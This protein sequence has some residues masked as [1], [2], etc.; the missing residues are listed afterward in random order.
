MDRITNM[1]NFTLPFFFLL[2]NLSCEKI[3]EQQTK[4]ETIVTENNEEKTKLIEVNRI[5]ERIK[6]CEDALRWRINSNDEKYKEEIEEFK[7]EL[8]ILRIAIEP[9][10]LEEK[11]KQ[12][13]REAEERIRQNAIKEAKR[14]QV[15]NFN[16]L[17][18]QMREKDLKEKPKKEKYYRDTKG[19]ILSESE[20]ESSLFEISVNIQNMP[21]G[22]DKWMA[23]GFYEAL[24][25]EYIRMQ[26]EGPIYEK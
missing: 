25:M 3:S 1:L 26:I 5:K 20:I 11:K 15:A 6:F 21:D 16:L 17:E 18:Q 14:Q 8:R 23:Q 19:K 7:S 4:Q 10:E 24:N 13:Q 12:D 2:F 22:P 9:Y